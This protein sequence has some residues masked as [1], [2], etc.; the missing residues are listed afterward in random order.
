MSKKIRIGIVGF[1]GIA[2]GAHLPGYVACK[3]DVEVVAVCDIDDNALAIAAEKCGLPQERLFHDYKD[4]ISSNFVDAVDICTPNY[5]H[6][7]IANEVLKAGKPF[8]VEKPAGINYREVLSLYNNVKKAN[9]PA[10]VCFSW[11]YKP[12]TRYI[13]HLIDR[14]EIGNLYHI[15]VRCI[16]NSGLWEGRRLEWRFDK[17][18]A[19][20]GVLG[21]LGSHMI[22]ITRFFGE[23]F[24]SV[25]A[26]SGI[27]VKK[28]QKIGSDEIAEVT[29]DDWCNIAGKLK[30]NI[31]VTIAVSRCATTI[32]DLI[33]FEL[34]G[35]NGTIKYTYLNRTQNI[36]ICVG[37]T[38]MEGNG[39][40]NIVPPQS[41]HANQSKSFVDLVNGKIDA[42]TAQLIQGVECQKVLEAAELSINTGR[43]IKISELE[44]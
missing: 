15:Y 5:I 10:F 32:D 3:D 1:G 40:H 17:E 44:A 16:K 27:I 23:E 26:Q 12:Y 33:E 8:S 20:T 4:L 41:F 22:D 34:F 36:E 13:K 11:R 29:T 25:F 30:S 31:G 37:K 14:G 2:R 38:D 35:D 43:S 19:G 18:K 24:E 9:V 7:E 39:R 28:R 6:C 42:Y 21:D